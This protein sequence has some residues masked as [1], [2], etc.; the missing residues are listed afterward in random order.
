MSAQTRDELAR[1]RYWQGQLLTAGDLS[2]QLAAEEELR[3][4]H[5]RAVHEAYGVAVGLGA[6]LEGDVL[7][8]EC[9]AAYDCNGRSLLLRTER[10]IDLPA[11]PATSTTLVLSRDPAQPD[12]VTLTWKPR[13]VVNP[14]AEIAL[15]RFSIDP[16]GLKLDPDFQPIVA[17]PLA[18]PRIATGETIKG[19][20]PWGENESGVEVFIDTSA[21]GFTRKPH[22]F[23][24]V[25][26]GNRSGVKEGTVDAEKDFP[27][28][29]FASIADP[30]TQGFTFRLMLRRI[31]RESLDLVSPMAQLMLPPSEDG[32]TLT[33]NGKDFVPGDNIARLLPLARTASVIKSLTGKTATLEVP[34]ADLEGPKVAY[35]NTARFALVT[36]APA[37]DTFFEVRVDTPDNFNQGS[38]VVRLAD[39]ENSRPAKVDSIDDDTLLLVTSIVSLAE[40]DALAVAADTTVVKSVD[41]ADNRKISVEA[42]APFAVGDVVVRLG[43]AIESSAPAKVVEKKAG[44]ILLLSQPIAGLQA[45]SRLGLARASGKVLSIEDHTGQ[46]KIIVNDATRF[47]IGDVVA[48]LFDDGKISI[49]VRVV[50]VKKIEN[51]LTLS[52]SIPELKVNDLIGAADFR[53]R[54]TAFGVSGDGKTVTVNDATP[55]ASQGSAPVYVARIDDL[56]RAG[57]PSHVSSTD[58][59][60]LILEQPLGGLKVGDVIALCSFPVSVLVDEVQSERNFS[61]TPAGVLRAGDVV[62]LGAA[63]PGTALRLGLVAEVNGSVVRLA[64]TTD[65]LAAGDRVT[66]ATIS[67]VV[68]VTQ[69]NAPEKFIVEQQ[70]RVRVGDFLAVIDGW[71]QARPPTSFV[72]ITS[73]GASDEV[74]TLSSR[75]DG[76]LLNDTVGLPSIDVTPSFL[77]I[78]RLDNL[79][80]LRP[81]EDELLFAGFDRL[82]GQTQSLFAKVLGVYKPTKHVLLQGEPTAAQSTLRPE[83]LSASVLF[84]GGSSL[85]LIQKHEL[86]VKWLAVGDSDPMPRTCTAAAEPADDPCGGV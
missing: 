56:L 23:A 78:V 36:Q 5:N 28:A 49:P 54:V 8:L 42:S 48:K 74:I 64:G 86:F 58:K 26:V 34:L 80:E 82:R 70:K 2:T 57:L 50:A 65:G 76:L 77:F 52:A 45:G 62:M 25:L 18:R 75:L 32:L 15:A 84:V 53:V 40:G 73:R 16:D 14:N 38:I 12:G 85:A 20:T 9:G 31:T 67:G 79:P 46:S 24:D 29:W 43:D 17:R 30:S 63:P 47:A 55:F 59:S 4:L 81:I 37:P 72:T 71:R 13:E 10:R 60:K 61:V 44:D 68:G 27:L 83:D 7:K 51:R 69:G 41:S 22:Y 19:Q 6:T 35:G 66:V 33:L 39:A 11:D 21:A 1:V 3:R